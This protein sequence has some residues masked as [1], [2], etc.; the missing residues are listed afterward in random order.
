MFMNLKNTF[1]IFIK[2][3]IYS[4]DIGPYIDLFFLVYSK[5]RYIYDT[6]LVFL[7]IK[8]YRFIPVYFIIHYVFKKYFKRIS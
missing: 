4:C 1:V 6:N 5:K 7:Q 8:T 3:H 2:G